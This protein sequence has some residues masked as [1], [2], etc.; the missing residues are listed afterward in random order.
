MRTRQTNLELL[1]SPGT[2]TSL[3]LDTTTT[4]TRSPPPGDETNTTPTLNLT[5]PHYLTIYPT[6]TLKPN[7]KSTQ[8][9]PNNTTTT[10]QTPEQPTPPPTTNTTTQTPQPPPQPSTTTTQ[11]QTNPPPITTITTVL[12]LQKRLRKDME[13]ADEL[14]NKIKS[15]FNI[16]NMNKDKLYKLDGKFATL[17]KYQV[18]STYQ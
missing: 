12:D 18:L 16:D 3:I 15:R 2:P 1:R 10:T 17:E 9:E 8:Y 5:P 13:T 7:H 11:T 14:I 4:P 6:L